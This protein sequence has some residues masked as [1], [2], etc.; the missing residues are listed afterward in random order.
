MLQ[1]VGCLGGIL[2]STLPSPAKI[3]SLYLKGND[4]IGDIPIFH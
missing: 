4:P 1:C 3:G 2:G